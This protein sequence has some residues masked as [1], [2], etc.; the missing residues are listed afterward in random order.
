MEACQCAL[1]ALALGALCA[2]GSTFGAQIIGGKDA[3]PHSRPYMASLQKDG[4]HR[5]GGVLVHPQWVLTAAHCLSTRPQLLK[6]RLVLGLHTL[7]QPSLAFRIR[8][9]VQH[10]EYR[11]APALKNDLLLLQLDGKV[12]PSKTIQPLHLP[13][14]RQV[15]AAGAW[16]SVAGWGVTHQGGQLARALQ[17]LDVQVLD[18]RMCNNS[19]FWQGALTPYMVCLAADKNKAPCKG[20]SGGPLVCGKGWLAG[21]LSFS[22]K[23]CTD[24]FKPTVATTVAPYVS[25]IKK[26]IRRWQS[27]PP[28]Q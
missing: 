25:W 24:V 3:A 14:S 17:E 1:L 15:V 8:A 20:D 16:C 26:V 11:P 6:L 5:C 10:P 7:G 27:P 23:V 13:R 12:K 18:S 9:A 28:A 22:S 21:I 4:S 19:R 2:V